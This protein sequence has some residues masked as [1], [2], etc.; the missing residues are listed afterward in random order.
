VAQVVFGGLLFRG[1]FGLWQVDVKKQHA[2]LYDE[3]PEESKREEVEE[4][5]T[6]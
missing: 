5:P 6:W 2:P 3:K 4:V 1:A